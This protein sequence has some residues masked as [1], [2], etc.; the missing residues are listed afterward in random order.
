MYAS[1]RLKR[2]LRKEGLDVTMVPL[3]SGLPTSIENGCIHRG[4]LTAFAR[5]SILLRKIGAVI[6]LKGVQSCRTKPTEWRR[7]FSACNYRQWFGAVV[8][9][10]RAEAS[11]PGG[12]ERFARV[13][14]PVHTSAYMSPDAGR[15]SPWL[16][17]IKQ[18]RLCPKA[19]RKCADPH[20]CR[21][22]VDYACDRRLP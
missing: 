22:R 21:I 20:R 19:F 10:A 13:R 15:K 17:A 5:V 8:E 2:L 16:A 1:L 18:C 9:S 7:E 6:L 11:G 14:V 3:G 12:L 4:V